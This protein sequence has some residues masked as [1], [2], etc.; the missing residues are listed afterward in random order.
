VQ[1]EALRIARAERGAEPYRQFET[2]RGKR[3][4]VLSQRALSLQHAARGID[5]GV[6]QLTW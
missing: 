1:L 5:H 6:S 2:E 4:L 3:C